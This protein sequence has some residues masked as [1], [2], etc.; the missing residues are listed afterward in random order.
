MSLDVAIAG[1]GIGGLTAALSLADAGFEVGVF[2][3]VP[4]LRALG[5]GINLLP[6]AVRELDELGLR[7]PL[8]AAGV[9]CG[10]L[11]YFTKRGERIWAEPRGLRAGYRWPQISIHRGTLQMQLLAAARARLGADRIQL[12]MTLDRFESLA[13]GG[14][15]AHF[16]ER[17]RGAAS[18]AVEA[19]LLVAADGIHSTARRAFYP[20]EG[21]PCWNGAVMWRGTA[22]GAPFFDGQTMIMAGHERQK[23]VSY[24]ITRAHDSRAQLNFV[25]EL[26]FDATRLDERE[27]WSKPGRLEDFL[28]R[29][30]SWR[31]PW[32]D[33]P[34]L[35][36][37]AGAV[38]VYPMID[39][40]PL[41]RWSFGPVTLLGDAA[42]PMYPIGSNGASQAILDAR[43]LTGCLRHYRA[44]PE[45]A[46]ARY[47]EIRRAAT[48][49]IVHA[50]R[51]Q[52]PESVMQLVESRAP[53]GF[54]KIDDV[55][56]EDE[57]HSIAESYKRVAG[58]S[59]AELNARE[60]LAAPTA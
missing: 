56:G 37:A 21:P 15:R 2:E 43:V 16:A 11:A 59:V 32:L 57:L 34:A 49:E 38:W 52:G 54:A 12:G 19:R 48:S 4:E 5:V 35:I 25:A 22:E 42:H 28:P 1:A 46:L 36:R 31:F 14:V 20:D 39:R 33:V 18:H 40:D 53:D 26:R 27:D 8:E 3:S 51:R 41:P 24:P 13:G 9:C 47:D 23:F 6:H 58:F 45:R 10:E 50:N 7:A 30:A 44:D 60:S 17:A 55:I 29:F